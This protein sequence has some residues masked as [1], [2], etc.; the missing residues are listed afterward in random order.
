MQSF[1]NKPG[2]DIVVDAF[3]VVVV[4]VVVVVTVD[5]AFDATPTE[6]KNL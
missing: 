1:K 5:E 6:D 2:V 4:V 3:V